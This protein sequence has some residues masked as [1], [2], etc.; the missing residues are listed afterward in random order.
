MPYTIPIW[1]DLKRSG[2]LLGTGLG[3]AGA[4]LNEVPRMALHYLTGYNAPSLLPGNLDAFHHAVNYA[5]GIPAGGP[6]AGA[7]VPPASNTKAT[8]RKILPKPKNQGPVAP[9]KTKT[10]PPT[11]GVPLP[12]QQLLL[13]NVQDTSQYLL[14]EQMAIPSMSYTGTPGATYTPQAALSISPNNSSFADIMGAVLNQRL[15]ARAATT[16]YTNALAARKTMAVGGTPYIP[17]RNPLLQNRMLEISTAAGQARLGALMRE[18]QTNPVLA[19][20]WSGIMGHLSDAYSS[21]LPQ[22]QFERGGQ[23]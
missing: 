1:E 16:N 12:P 21:I 20:I 5:F 11:Q 14:P 13:P 23:R 22:T 17:A 2:A 8:P 18:V 3:V 4:A 15:A 19:N 10:N 7:A 9:I 6:A